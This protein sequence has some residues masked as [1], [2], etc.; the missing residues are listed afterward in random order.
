MDVI[1]RYIPI[2][3]YSKRFYWN[4]IYSPIK[5]EKFPQM[6]M[7]GS[8]SYACSEIAWILLTIDTFS[9][10]NPLDPLRKS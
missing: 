10:S 9:E 7:Q 1:A 4:N 3:P 6:N 5:N 2:K 8:F